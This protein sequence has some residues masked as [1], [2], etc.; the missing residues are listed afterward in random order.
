METLGV[1]PFV[2]GDRNIF[3]IAATD[4][5]HFRNLR[6]GP[7]LKIKTTALPSTVSP[8]R[9]CCSALQ[10]EKDGAGVLLADP[11]THSCIDLYKQVCNYWFVYYIR[12]CSNCKESFFLTATTIVDQV[13]VLVQVCR[14]NFIKKY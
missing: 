4:R 2:R 14:L 13:Q 8:F 11:P 1:F 10:L 5:C 12:V 7:N 6:S 3:K 9:L